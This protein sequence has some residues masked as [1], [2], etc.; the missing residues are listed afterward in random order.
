MHSLL[1][2]LALPVCL[3]PSPLGSLLPASALGA[4][5]NGLGTV[6]TVA[7]PGFC[8]GRPVIDPVSN[9]VRALAVDKDGVVYVDTGPPGKG[10]IA[11]VDSAG[12]ASLIQTGIFAGSQGAR[13]LLPF[14]LYPPGRLAPDGTGGV[15]VAAETKILQLNQG[16]R[17]VAGRGSPTNTSNENGG[18]AGPAIGASF[19]RIRGIATDESGSLFVAD[20]VDAGRETFRIR[21][22]NRTAEPR[23]F[24]SG[25]SLEVTVTPGGIDTILGG[26][27]RTEPR[28]AQ[29]TLPGSPSR[30][31]DEPLEGV[32]GSMAAA[33]SRLYVAVLVGRQDHKLGTA[34]S[35]KSVVIAANI[36][37]QTLNTNGVRIEAGEAA[38]VAGGTGPTVRDETLARKTPLSYVPG[39]SADEGGNLYLAEERENRILRVDP[40]GRMANFAGMAKSAP[41][42]AEPDGNGHPATRTR[43]ERPFD[44]KVGPQGRVYI[45]DQLNGQV[46]YVDEAGIVHGSLGRGVGLSVDCPIAGFPRG[47]SPAGGGTARRSSGP[48]EGALQPAWRGDPVGIDTDDKGAVYVALSALGLVVRLDFSGAAVPVAGTLQAPASCPANRAARGPCSADGVLAKNARIEAPTSV[49]SSRRGRG[50]YVFENAKV[51]Y[52]NLESKAVRVN[53]VSVGPKSIRTVAGTGALP[54]GSEISAEGTAL[55]VPLS[56]PGSVA[57]D[58][59]G[60]LFIADYSNPRVRRV[61]SSGRLTTIVGRQGTSSAEDCCKEPVDLAV[62]STGNLYISDLLAFR[63]WFVNRGDQPMIVHGQRVD[64]GETRS[65]AGSGVSGFAGDGGPAV[66]AQL[67]GPAGIAVDRRRNL[68]IADRIDHSVRRVDAAGTITTVAGVGTPGFSGD[69]LDGR[70]TSLNEP[71]D[72]AVDGCGNLLIADQQNDR[73][74]RLN[75]VAACNSDSRRAESAGRGPET[76]RKN[77][78]KPS[79][80]IAGGLA[81]VGIVSLIIV[82]FRRGPK[83]PREHKKPSPPFI[84]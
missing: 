7:G 50:F 77:R 35:A 33:P 43:L 71:R 8:D 83:G 23:T 5:S 9:S 16:T 62:D 25:T 19:R 66:A 64:P 10:E 52:V 79:A 20:E 75:L 55:K 80:E 28:A 61:D 58:A 32:P 49:A 78:I 30:A 82:L 27:R 34:S 2:R 59:K 11:K 74:R 24:Y 21:F 12:R 73:I 56:Y 36:G 76:I 3:L 67:S 41:A 17:V 65:V 38:T 18:D 81:L 45:S 54:Q 6:D 69:G 68:Y 42:K 29:A 31:K 46:R 48:R 22:I 72:V 26:S 44:V 1:A 13:A 39:I 40:S 53:G 70:L 63:V 47:R 57:A 15:L 4:V 84:L 14:D 60:N 51:R 37:G